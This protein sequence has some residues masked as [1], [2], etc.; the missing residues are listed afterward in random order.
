MK[1]SVKTTG[2]SCAAC[3]ARIEK[4]L[5]KMPGVVSAHADFADNRVTVE[6]DGDVLKETDISVAIRKLGYGT[7]EGNEEEIG[8]ARRREA[9]SLKRGLWIS[10]IFTIVL[11]VFAMGPMFGLKLPLHDRPLEYAL[12]EL[13]LCI[14]V[15]ISG[16][17]FYIRG[18]PALL[19]GGPTMDSL[20]SVGTLAAVVYSL[21][22]TY[23]IFCGAGSLHSLYYDSAAMIIT[24]VS[25]GKYMEAGS[26]VKTDEALRGLAGMA[27]DTANIERGA[28]ISAVPI[29]EV[30]V[31]DIAVVKPGEKVSVDGVVIDGETYI[32]ESML[33]GESMPVL[34]SL[35]A[36][37]FCGTINTSGSIRV[38]VTDVGGDTAL[39]KI[40][41]MVR[42][43]RG[44][45][46]PVSRV[47]DR[48][49]AVFVP[50][51]ILIAAAAG[52]LW[53]LAGRGFEFA[54]VTFISVLVISCPCALGLATPMAV[55][56]GTGRSAEFGILFRTAAA[57]EM[58]G[59]V[60]DI[61]LDKTGTLTE[62]RPRVV[63][64][65]PVGDEGEFISIMA[66]AELHS[67]HPIG[68][69][70]VAYAESAG[71][72]IAGPESFEAVVGK[73]ITCKVAGKDV[74]AG[75]ASLL[76]DRG[77]PVGDAG[78][79]TTC[80]H[81]AVDGTY[82]GFLS[83]SDPVKPQSAEAVSM[84]KA[85]DVNVVMVTGDSKASAESVAAIVGID[86]YVSGALPGDKVSAVKRMQARGSDVA[87]AGDGINDSPALVQSDLGIAVSN[88]TDITMDSADVVLLNDDVRHIPSVLHIGRTVL[89]NIRQN[90]FFA[91]CYNAVCIP[92]AAGLPVLLGAG[93]FMQMPMLAALA[94]SLSSVSVVSNALRLRRMKLP[95]E[96]SRSCGECENCPVSPDVGGCIPP[97]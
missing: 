51:V 77:I 19:R 6:Y 58:A 83:V 28:G 27:P 84:L 9:A 37:V 81:M 26:L 1:A 82:A 68:K 60:T 7:L 55:T 5:A 35:G 94:M 45:K 44:S 50:A 91:F 8:E 71:I 88:G 73:G 85:M 49:A 62:G 63:N 43:A 30:A 79:G 92:I 15:L 17:R 11:M 74:V 31:D 87:V 57:L 66:S 52:V 69:A 90:L 39:N 97:G 4:E 72:A 2:M 38:R 21:F 70:I 95:Y 3:S 20:V 13:A 65:S 23:Q 25:V 64:V 14:P 56:V 36:H 59:R 47:A 40:M 93:E 48:V 32:D 76:E 86:K 12:L 24:L 54:L 78:C 61:V 33:T 41:Q 16:R 18:I 22:A 34:K 46:A 29:S 75:N 80:V 10:A 96:V 67:E 89:K 53:F 42:D